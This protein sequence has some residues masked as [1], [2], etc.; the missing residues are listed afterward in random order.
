[1]MTKLYLP[2]LFCILVNRCDLF[3]LLA[4]NEEDKIAVS[5]E[6]VRSS[7]LYDSVWFFRL[8]FICTI[9]R[10]INEVQRM[11]RMRFLRNPSNFLC[12]MIVI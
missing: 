1:M 12:A 9:A 10:L 11:P 8:R 5:M 2:A 3:N 6:Q 4:R 7:S